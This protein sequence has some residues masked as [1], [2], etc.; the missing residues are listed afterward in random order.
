VALNK[1]N[2]KTKL[3][4]SS[5][6]GREIEVPAVF[7]ERVREDIAQRFFEISK[8]QQPYAPGFE[9]GRKASAS[10]IVKHR[11]HLWKTAYGHGISR[12]P[13]KIM[14]RRGTQFFWVAATVSMARKGRAA[15]PPKI[16]HFLKEMKMNKKE[17]EIAIKSA[18]SATSNI[19]L[20][21][22]RYSSLAGFSGKV[23][24]PFVVDESVLKL[25]T[26]EFIAF[27]RSNLK[28]FE[29]ILFRERTQRA[30]K[31]KR[32]N[33]KYK[34]NA[35]L[36]MVIGSDEHKSFSGIE[37]R[38]LDELEIGDLFPLGRLTIFSEKAIHELN[39]VKEKK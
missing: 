34:T 35:G 20:I 12:I 37:I 31:G 18:I 25:K 21:K 26:K 19:N 6:K 32:R 28:E 9:S 24:L 8:E 5:G 16:E 39:Q 15:H 22:K 29:G 30:G 7:G 13:R 33:R 23:E 2:M 1:N 11:R 14:S 4:T 17:T 27:L 10:G 36:L 3:I 38:K